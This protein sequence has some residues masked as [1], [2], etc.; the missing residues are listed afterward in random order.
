MHACMY[1]TNVIIAASS[2]QENF[3]YHIALNN[4]YYCLYISEITKKMV[5]VRII[6]CLF[7]FIIIQLTIDE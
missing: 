2:L 7:V 5:L 1:G 3:Y 6:L 4:G